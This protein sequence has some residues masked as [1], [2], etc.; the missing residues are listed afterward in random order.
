M[1]PEKQSGGRGVV[2]KFTRTRD[3]GVLAFW[4]GFRALSPLLIGSQTLRDLFL[5]FPQGL[6]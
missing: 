1:N 5:L 3:V 4:E 6:H 2:K